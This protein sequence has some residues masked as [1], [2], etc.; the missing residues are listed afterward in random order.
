MNEWENA[1]NVYNK[2]IDQGFLIGYLKKGQIF[3]NQGL[4]EEAKQTYQSAL[5]FGLHKLSY[6]NVL[7]IIE[8][9]KYKH[10]DQLIKIIESIY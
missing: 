6:K 3:E 7:V 9:N 2:I 8:K 10:F 1:L 5:W 4:D